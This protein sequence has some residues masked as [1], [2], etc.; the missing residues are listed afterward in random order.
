MTES[1]QQY[2]FTLYGARY[3]K[4][5]WESIAATIQIRAGSI[6]DIS[7]TLCHG[8]ISRND[9][10]LDGFLLMPGLINAHD[11]LAFAL[12]PKLGNPPY[13]NYIEW[14]EDIHRQFSEC[15]AKHKSIPKDV[16][17][18]WG[19]IRNLLCGVT[20]VSHHDAF[21]PVM[22]TKGFPVKVVQTNGWAH[23]PAL[24]GNLHAARKA[25]RPGGTFVLHA[26]E[27]IDDLAYEELWK[28]DRVGLLDAETVLVHGLAIDAIGV[29][30]MRQRATSLIV[31]PSSNNFLFERLPDIS[32]LA[33]IEKIALGSDSPLTAEGDLLDELHFIMRYCGVAPHAAYR[34]VTETSSEIL[35]LESGTGR[36]KIDGP[37]DLVAIRDTGQDIAARLP[38]LSHR[39]IELVIIN[40]SVQLASEALIDRLPHSL[41][42]CMEPLWV[43][44]STRWLRAPVGM[45]LEQAEKVLGIGQVK[46]GGK[47]IHIPV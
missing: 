22:L 2:S 37:G 25:T 21:S 4:G 7:Q 28:L 30:L 8:P 29:E 3:V 27:G 34:M 31:C 20:T 10:D 46:L 9:I 39:D 14:G 19:G 36:I 32:L 41:K 47:S 11:H 18:L 40:G 23:S 45:L 17:V 44:G 15:I 33:K 26:C 35:R 24:G 12:F 1:I 42:Q 43:D 38:Q 5:P 16:R 6:A 13:R